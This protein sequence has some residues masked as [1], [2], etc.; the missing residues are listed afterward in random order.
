MVNNINK[1]KMVNAKAD[2]AVKGTV[3]V[4]SA[5]RGIVRAVNV[6][7]DSVAKAE[8]VSKANRASKVS[9]ETAAVAADAVVDVDV[10][11]KI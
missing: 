8:T 7:A 11:A 2:N 3:K 1:T 6:K 5:D 4:D 10:K 9:R